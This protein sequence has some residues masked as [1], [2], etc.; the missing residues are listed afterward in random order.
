MYTAGN[1]HNFKHVHKI[2][3][4]VPFIVIVTTREDVSHRKPASTGKWRDS[5]GTQDKGKRNALY[6]EC[7]LTT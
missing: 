6:N 5:C 2:L 3:H 7:R 1:W 4:H